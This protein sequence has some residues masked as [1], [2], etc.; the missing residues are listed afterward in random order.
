MEAPY[1]NRTAVASMQTQGEPQADI[2]HL[3]NEHH[4]IAYQAMKRSQE[5]Q[6]VHR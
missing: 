1:P 6:E 2:A 5:V 4:L 3:L